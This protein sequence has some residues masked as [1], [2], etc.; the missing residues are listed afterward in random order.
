MTPSSL[1][2]SHGL[3]GHTKKA[4]EDR[5]QHYVGDFTQKFATHKTFRCRGHIWATHAVPKKKAVKEAADLHE[6]KMSIEDRLAF[7]EGK[8]AELSAIFENNV[9]EIELHPEK[10]DWA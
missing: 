10:V 2:T 4:A 6:N 8:R 7:L 3:E 9:W 1:G 5:G